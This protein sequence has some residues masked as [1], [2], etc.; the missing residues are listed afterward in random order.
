[1]TV[2]AVRMVGPAMITLYTGLL[3]C[4]FCRV[5]M[6]SASRD[7]VP[8]VSFPSQSDVQIGKFAC[9]ELPRFPEVAHDFTA[10]S[11]AK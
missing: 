1:M 4:W 8:A 6:Y 11:A 5:V 7:N 2:S 10:S 9:V 3:G